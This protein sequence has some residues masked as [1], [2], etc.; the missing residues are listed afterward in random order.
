MLAASLRARH[1][2]QKPLC[3]R[4]NSIVQW[5]RPA[6]RVS[7]GGILHDTV[8]SRRRGPREHRRIFIA[9]RTS[10]RCVIS[11][12]RPPALACLTLH[13]LAQRPIDACL[14]AFIGFR[15]ALEP[16]D[17]IG[18]EAKCQLLLD[19]PI[20][21]PTL[22]AGPVE[23]FRRVR[24]VNGAIG[25]R[26]QRLQFRQLLTRLEVSFFIGF[27]FVGGGLSR[28]DDAADRLACFGFTA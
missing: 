22:G 17:D 20:E 14:I 24:G 26:P 18:V 10:G 23:Q 11:R 1:Q 9:S 15:V 27:P 25:Q 5:L 13:V 4:N 12:P 6:A 16:G 19:G 8:R 3:S 28:A 2:H 7:S 21:Q